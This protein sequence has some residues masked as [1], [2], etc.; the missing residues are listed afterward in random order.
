MTTDT[1]N[2]MKAA[3]GCST[4]S[5]D[6][7][8]RRYGSAVDPPLRQGVELSSFEIPKTGNRRQFS[9]KSTGYFP[10]SFDRGR[11]FYAFP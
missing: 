4:S 3:A 7:A 2:L 5:N 1:L 8:T 6:P 10:P 9:V 11:R